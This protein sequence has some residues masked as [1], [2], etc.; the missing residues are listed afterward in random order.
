MDKHSYTNHRTQYKQGQY[1]KAEHSRTQARMR[2]A[3][4]EFGR[5]E[6]VTQ[7]VW[8]PASTATVAVVG[9]GYVGLPLAVLAR[10]KGYEVVGIDTNHTIVDMLNRN[11][12][13]GYVSQEEAA[14][15]QRQGIRAYAGPAAVA[16]AQTVL[17]CVPTPVNEDRTPDLRP[18]IR[19]TTAI[20]PFLRKNALVIVESTVNP[21]VTA[22]VVLPILE[23]HGL[24]REET[25]FV[26]HCPERINPGDPKWNVRTIPRVL[27]AIGKRSLERASAF[28]ASVIDAPITP[29]GSLEEAE[30]VKMVENSFRD[31]NIAFVN[32]LARSFDRLG[33][34]V[35]R[36]IDG[37]ATKPFGFMAHYP[38]CGVG[39]HCIPVDPYYLIEH[40]RRN[41]F[42]HRLLRAARTVNNSMPDHTV[43]ILEEE[44]AR[45]GNSL[46]AAE[47]ALLGLAYKRDIADTRE[48]PALLIRDLL[49]EEG[50]TVRTYDP[51]VPELSSADSLESAL[52]GAHAIVLATDHSEFVSRLEPA[53]IRKGGTRIVVDGRNCLPKDAFLKADVRYR[54]IGR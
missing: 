46:L 23:R 15:I 44:F 18:L 12:A 30:A 19:A 50:A 13:P 26:A 48:S 34:D 20:A 51:Y 25:L 54:G 22:E 35:V 32:E 40:A 33:I 43:R 42:D 27:G 6:R 7:P 37:A 17:L 16:K 10:R 8:H 36:V 9:L 29:M 24:R 1:A 2:C 11:E 52:A 41:G 28:Y 49:N 3:T 47:V 38:G 45:D 14:E 39:G 4:A 53:R 21:G 5:R 31:I